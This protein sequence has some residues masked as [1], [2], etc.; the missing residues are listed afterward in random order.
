MPNTSKNTAPSLPSNTVQ[1]IQILDQGKPLAQSKIW[2]MIEDFYGNA[3]PAAWAEVTNATPY[4]P[5]SNAY[6][7]ET[8]AEMI[9]AFLRDY[10]PHTDKSQPIYVLELGTGMGAFSVFTLNAVCEKLAF[11]A[12]LKDIN[13]VYI[14]TDFTEH[15]L[16]LWESSPQI[17]DFIAQGLLDFAL[18]WPE[19]DETITL[20]KS[21]VTLRAGEVKNPLIIL[22]NYFFDSIRHDYYQ[23]NHGKLLQAQPALYRVCDQDTPTDSTPV[24]AHVQLRD[25][26][27]EVSA[28]NTYEDPALGMILTEYCQALPTGSF[29]FPLGAFRTLKNLRKI[30]SD[31]IF[32]LASDK[33]TQGLLPLQGHLA[34]PYTPHTGSFSYMVN[35]H[36][37]GEYFQQ[38]HGHTWHAPENP[39]LTSI[40]AL[41]IQKKGI[42]WENVEYAAETVF[43]GRNLTKNA[44]SLVQLLEHFGPKADCPEEI[45]VPVALACLHLAHYDPWVF[46]QCGEH[47][48]RGL[49]ARDRSVDV[50]LL[51]VLQNVEKHITASV[52]GGFLA[53]SWIRLLYFHLGV[54]DACLAVNECVFALF[55]PHRDYDYYHALIAEQRGEYDIALASFQRAS[56]HDPHCELSRDAVQRLQKQQP[57]RF[58]T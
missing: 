23:T 31:N 26:F 55:G 28:A 16:K 43:C 47:L 58:G 20:R 9:I 4:Y 2:P 56:A 46:H 11:F 5:T 1:T 6:I 53:Y 29:L 19:K 27:V 17:Q 38:S 13:L 30:S 39:S 34:V 24:L 45:L 10:A 41:L 49:P 7:G 33:G 37:I 14:M 50:E 36:A 51:H 8:Y 18:Y 44:Y 42:V 48:L 54:Y 52:V 32:L 22:A 25:H 21:G 57:L 3:G 12:S 40:A 35:F 15:N